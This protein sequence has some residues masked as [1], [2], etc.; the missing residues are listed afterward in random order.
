MAGLIVQI[1]ISKSLVGLNSLHEQTSLVKF[2]TPNLFASSFKISIIFSELSMPVICLAVFDK[3]MLQTPVPQ[4]I[5]R[6]SLPLKLA[7]Q[8]KALPKICCCIALILPSN[9]W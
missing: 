4:P 9:L 8:A 7:P 6:I 3:N 1:A 2:V 5:S